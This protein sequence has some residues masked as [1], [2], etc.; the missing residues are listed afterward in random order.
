[1]AFTAFIASFVFITGNAHADEGIVEGSSL[2]IRNGPGTEYESIGRADTGE[3]FP[4]VQQVND[5]VEI[6]LQH[7]TG[8]VSAEFITINESAIND[9]TVLDEDPD[10]SSITIKYQNTQ[11]REGPSTEYDIVNF[12]E[13]GAVFDIISTTGEWYEVVNETQ[14]GFVLKELVEK[15][16]DKLR[17]KGFKNKTVV[18]D[19]GH[20]GRDVGA[21][22]ANG[23][24]EKDIASL[25]AQELEQALKLLGANVLLT[26]QQDEFISLTS[27]VTYSNFVDTDAFISLHYNSVPELPNVSGIET[28]YYAKQ[29]A[30]MANYIH[31]G[32]I[33]ATGGSDRGAHEG[34]LLVLRLNMKPSVLLEL[35]FMSNPE[36]E[37]LLHTNGYQKK[38]V[39]GIVDGLGKYFN[40]TN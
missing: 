7:G 31:D 14:T 39:S 4:V 33:G 23:S 15:S 1:M 40:S 12:A 13:K 37:A 9:T 5:W 19:A 8:W 38:L 22:G 20:G 17:N 6:E 27:R 32:I 36:K 2:N 28:F 16:D 10:I 11:L 26:R 35:G 29:N 18:I 30:S 21:I 34:D 25:T 3:S 24:F